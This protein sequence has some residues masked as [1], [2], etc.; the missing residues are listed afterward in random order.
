MVGRLKADCP[1][2]STRSA[3]WDVFTVL[4][5]IGAGFVLVKQRVTWQ[6]GKYTVRK[7][8]PS[9]SQTHVRQARAP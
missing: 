6:A 9:F 1:N 2:Y 3:V 7:V 8:M 5:P 4:T